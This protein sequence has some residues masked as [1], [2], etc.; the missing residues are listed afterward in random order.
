MSDVKRISATSIFF[1]SM[2]YKLDPATGLIDYAQLEVTARLFRPR[3]IIAGTSAYAR[4]IDYARMKKVCEEVKAYLLADMAHISG[5]V[6]AKAI[7]SPFEHADVVTSTTHKT[8]RGARSGLIFYRKGVRAVDKKT[9]K[10][11]LYD[12]EDR[13]NFAVFPSLQGGPHNHAIAAV[14]VALK[15]ASSPA[16]RLYCQ[17]VLK[18]AK[19]MA[20]ALLQRG[21]TLVS[22]GTDNHLVLVDLRPKGIDGARAERVLELVSI[23]ANK[24]TCPG[25]RSALTPGGLRLGAPAL[26]SRHFGEEDFRKVVAFIDEGIALALDVKSKTSKL[27]EFKTFLLQD[28]ETQRRLADLR[29]RVETFARAFPMPGFSDR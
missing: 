5:L 26:T 16:F 6:A 4:L 25:D 27:Q 21:Y 12:L 19:A 24:N 17:Q 13:I 10:E 11:T 18:N 22:G 14:A 3:L 20:Q 2:P 28:A 15:Q 29:R 1:E 7:P 23:T 9:G 8:L